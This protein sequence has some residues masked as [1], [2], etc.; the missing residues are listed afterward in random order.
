MKKTSLLP[1]A[2]A[3][4]LAAGCAKSVS[5]G[6]NDANYRYFE[7]WA[8]INCPDAT[9][10]ALG[11]YVL[12]S[13]DGDGTVIM[14]SLYM[15]AEYVVRTLDGTVSSSSTAAMAQQLG[16]YSAQNFYGPGFWYTGDNSLEAGFEELLTDKHVGLKFKAV[17]PGWLATGDRYDTAQEYI[18]N[19]SGTD[20]IY[21]VEVVESFNDIVKWEV[22]S[23]VRYVKR[24][25]PEMDPAD[26]VSVDPD[27]LYDKKYG[28]YYIQDTP[29]TCPD[30][31]FDTS[32]SVY[33]NYIGRLLNGQVFDT[34]VK[35]TAKFY[36]IYDSSNT[37]E[38]SLINWGETYDDLTMTSSE[39]SIIDG[40]KFA[41]FQMKPYEKGT[42][43]FYSA[44]G[45]S[46]S[47]SGD[48]IPAY[49]PLRFDIELVDN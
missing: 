29:S 40:F 25:W 41:I 18:D 24:T 45:Y 28:F 49:S 42:T 10:T 1:V 6:L 11:S 30:S 35:D 33:I 7:A 12:E 34:N 5:A 2:A 9:K 32:A 21:E 23:L 19:V 46:Y 4:V 36:G 26:T 38:P 44:Y 47:G 14:D 27:S 17:I 20:Y 13:T 31:T 8:S 22:D 3:L 37:Y 48:A 15:R 43:V 39:S 16:T